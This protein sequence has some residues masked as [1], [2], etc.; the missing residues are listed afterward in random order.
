MSVCVC[1]LSTC[2]LL[3]K[4]SSS[5]NSMEL[6]QKTAWICPKDCNF[7]SVACNSNLYTLRLLMMLKVLIALIHRNS[8]SS[9]PAQFCSVCSSSKTLPA[10]LSATGLL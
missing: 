5:S 8:P 9:F 7:S 6:A 1:G 10:V 4:G 2:L 3:V